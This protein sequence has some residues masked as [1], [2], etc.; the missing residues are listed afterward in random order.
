MV[1]H[2]NVLNKNT[3]SGY[4]ITYYTV[5]CITYRRFGGNILLLTGSKVSKDAISII[6]R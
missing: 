2:S 3:V 5:Y 6:R 4:R 1:A